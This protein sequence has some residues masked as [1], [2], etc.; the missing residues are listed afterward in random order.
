MRPMHD[1]Y[2]SMRQTDLRRVDLNLLVVLEALLEE[3]TSPAPRIGS[4]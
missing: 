3:R 4:A 2:S 1:V